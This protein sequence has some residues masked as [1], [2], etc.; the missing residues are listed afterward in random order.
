M[1]DLTVTIRVENRPEHTHVNLYPTR[2]LEVE[3]VLP[4]LRGL[5]VARHGSQR[6]VKVQAPEEG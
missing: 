2:G 3:L 5:N 1:P 6:T 4:E